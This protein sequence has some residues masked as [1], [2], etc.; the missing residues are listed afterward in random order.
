MNLKVLVFLIVLFIQCFKSK[1]HHHQA[2]NK[3]KKGSIDNN[4]IQAKGELKKVRN[5]KHNGK[6]MISVYKN[7][8]DCFLTLHIFPLEYYVEAERGL[9]RLRF[10]SNCY[11]THDIVLISNNELDEDVDT[12]TKIDLDIFE[13]KYKMVFSE[14]R[15]TAPAPNEFHKLVFP[16]CS[17]KFR[18]ENHDINTMVDNNI[19]IKKFVSPYEVRRIANF[20]SPV[21]CLADKHEKLHCNLY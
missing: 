4:E 10:F 18:N 1:K 8:M 15:S 17:L 7:P 19:I 20:K 9:L 3:H 5:L 14:V 13:S 12:I 11:H 6:F 2:V 16:R 21:H